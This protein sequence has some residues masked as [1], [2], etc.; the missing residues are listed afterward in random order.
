MKTTSDLVF[1]SDQDDVWF[2]LKNERVAGVAK[3]NP[4]ALVVMND[5]VLK[6]GE[7]NEVGL[8]KVSQIQSAGLPLRQMPLACRGTICTGF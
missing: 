3:R 1:L 4:Q 6:D 7:L 5:A 8:T 2:P